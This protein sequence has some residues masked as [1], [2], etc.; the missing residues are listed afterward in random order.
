MLS[1]E[2]TSTIIPKRQGRTVVSV[3]KCHTSS[4]WDRIKPL[5]FST[6]LQPAL[7]CDGLLAA[8]PLFNA[9]RQLTPEG[10]KPARFRFPSE[11]VIKLGQG[12]T[13]GI[14]KDTSGRSPLLLRLAC[15]ASGCV[16]PTLLVNDQLAGTAARQTGIP[17]CPTTEDNSSTTITATSTY[18]HP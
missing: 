10:H 11:G 3:T 6:N 1:S 18:F 16:S 9:Q 14:L 4:P 2:N 13:Q 12:E 8:F 17:L 7:L 5:F 15:K